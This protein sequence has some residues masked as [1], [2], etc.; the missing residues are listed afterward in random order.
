MKKLLLFSALLI[1]ACSG[2]NDGNSCIY[3]PTLQTNEVTDIT[4]TSATLNGV[5]SILSENCDVP[6]N[7]EQGFVYSTEIQPTLEDTKVNV[8]GTNISTTIDGLTSN[9]TYY[10]RSFLTNN[11]GD[12]YGDEVSFTTIAGQVLLNTIEAT[13]ITENSA[14]SGV[15]I[16]SDGNTTIASKG[17]CWS[18]IQNP[19]TIDDNIFDNSNSD[20]FT[21]LI[22]NLTPNTQYF[23]RSYATNE[24]DT[25]YGEEI[26]F[27]TECVMPNIQI[28]Q[29][30]IRE[31]GSIS[32]NFTYEAINS[33]GYSIDNIILSYSFND[34]NISIDAGIT[35]QGIIQIENLIP[36]T[37]YDNIELKFI[38]S[39]CGNLIY[40]YNNFTTPSLYDVGDIAEGGIVIHMYPN[41]INGIVASEIDAGEGRWA[42][43]TT[44]IDYG[45]G[46]HDVPSS[47]INNWEGEI[48]DGEQY[49]EL[50]YDFI[51]IGDGNN[52][53]GYFNDFL[54]Q[55]VN[56]IDNSKAVELC[57]SFNHNGYN[58]WYLPHI[59]TLY[60]MYQLKEQ[61]VLSNFQNTSAC[62][63]SG[64]MLYWSS[65]G[66]GG[67][68]GILNF[69]NGDIGIGSFGT[70]LRVR[71]VRKF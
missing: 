31:D 68:G 2:D 22:E 70:M 3:E 30:V 60:L 34:E 42:C 23:V 66:D 13:N 29:E 65:C 52:S 62:F 44:N 9:T 28:S 32:A 12:F 51:T 69:G 45:W 19:T 71:P 17:I 21:T 10:V 39:E 8:N 27:I 55:G 5:I 1:F 7:I 26:V 48:G 50:I 67:N 11:F 46:G 35:P 57:Y 63:N 4:E 15:E 38:S 41:G 64:E 49:S 47:N 43:N 40:N 20:M 37:L 56:C 36:F 61:G 24:F 59:K 54:C 25:Y 6:N 33:N 58:D 14:L 18:T 16:I 53:D